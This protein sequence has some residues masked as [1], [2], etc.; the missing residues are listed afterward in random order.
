MKNF[1]II[2]TILIAMN[3]SKTQA[4]TV[5]ML[6]DTGN[7][8][9][10][11]TSP[12]TKLEVVGNTKLG[13]RLEIDSNVIVKDSVTINKRLTVDQDV[14]IK[15]QS[16]FLGDGKFKSDLR[17]LGTARMK[18]KLVVDSTANFNDKIVVDGLGRFNGDLKLNGDFIF[19][20]NKRIKYF[21]PS[22]GNPEVIT[23]GG[24]PPTLPE[25][26]FC[27]FPLPTTTTINQFQGMIQAYG[28][29][30]SFTNVMSM[31]FDGANGIIDMAGKNSL[32]SSRLLINYYCGKD[33][34]MNTGANGGNVTMTSSELGKVGI[35]LDNPLTKLDVKGD[36]MVR[37]NPTQNTKALSIFDEV[38]SK[39]V[40]RVMSTGHIYATEV[41]VK[42]TPFPDYVF[43]KDYNLSTITELGDYIN[44]NNRLP[45]M[46]TATE[47]EKN[48]I[49]VGE[50]QTKLVE[51]IEELTLYI[52][53]LNK[54][55]E[56]LEKK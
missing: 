5:N 27:V 40:F 2:M 46:P 23:F 14:L 34:F 25:D 30:G 6:P 36:L 41:T 29:Y 26:G 8:G 1:V 4:Q 31:G 9:V 50:L 44:K 33:I 28:D 15:G 54:R 39:D 12:S 45:N 20:D 43:A 48:G 56:E 13:G 24:N 49:G 52:L 32:G 3:L 16:V 35:G 53:E 18:E 47:V 42:L 21:P 51:K 11:T 19:G 38:S 17:V 10:G 22:G 7:V 37:I 55:I